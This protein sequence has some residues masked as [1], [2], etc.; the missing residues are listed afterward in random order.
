[1]KTFSIDYNDGTLIISNQID[2][3]RQGTLVGE[4]DGKLYLGKGVVRPQLRNPNTG[5]V[6]EEQHVDKVAFD[7]DLADVSKVKF[8][9]LNELRDQKCQLNSQTIYFAVKNP[10]A[11]IEQDNKRFESLSA[12]DFMS[13]DSTR[14]IKAG[15]PPT[16]LIETAA[17]W[18]MFSQFDVQGVRSLALASELVPQYDI[19]KVQPDAPEALRVATAME[20]IG[21]FYPCFMMLRKTAYNLAKQ[22]GCTVDDLYGKPFLI[23]RDPALPDGTS[24]IPMLMA[25]ILD[26]DNGCKVQE[27]IV[28][29]PENKF[30][31][32]MGGDFDGDYIVCVNPTPTLQP[33]GVVARPNFRQNGKKYASNDIIQQMVQNSEESITS[34]LGPI[35]LSAARLA[36]RNLDSDELRAITAGVAQGSVEAKKHSVDAQSIM[37]NATHIFEDVRQGNE[38]GAYPYF[39][40]YI[41]ELKN[42][43]DLDKKIEKWNRLK[44]ALP[45]WE[46][47]G[48]ALEKALCARFRLLDQLFND[49]QFLRSQQR[50]TLPK[51]ITDAARTLCSFEAQEAVKG[52]T[53]TYLAEVYRLSEDIY[54]ETDEDEQENKIYRDSIL[55]GVRVM[56]TK[57][58]LAAVTGLIGNIQLELK[59]AQYALAGFAPSKVAARFVPAEIFEE[60]GKKTKRIII[61]LTGLT[62]ENKIYK[63]SDIS[64]IPSCT[65]EWEAF[66]NGM[67]EVHVT[68]ISNTKHS[69][70]VVLE[71]KQ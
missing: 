39:S 9:P 15:V 23:H 21:D 60:L 22:C 20:C 62:W 58:Q 56:R 63:V 11:F 6:E 35:I 38:D 59:D 42:T 2:K 26:W 7:K 17:V 51:F 4:L 16:L 19:R 45:M 5:D 28:L 67:S 24:L 34:L 48:T 25:G 36:E 49:I 66:S 46:E 68:I 53:D 71:V 30:W 10:A 65:K 1:M 43:K 37:E 31:T 44:E 32:T 8:Y 18:K 47:R 55:D 64:P 40:D 69:T 13:K 61:P 12:F 54:V 29:N 33:R 27:G 50:V 57:F 70:R 3:P 41:N 52:L 14:K